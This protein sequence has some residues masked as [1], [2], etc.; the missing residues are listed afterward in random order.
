M[1]VLIKQ[2]RV[3]YV[4]TTYYV[5]LQFYNTEIKLLV[6]IRNNEFHQAIPLDESRDEWAVLN[7]HERKQIETQLSKHQWNDPQRF[8]RNL[9]N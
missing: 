5:C 6:T 7:A 3:A 2:D 8:V 1:G 9:L 4:F